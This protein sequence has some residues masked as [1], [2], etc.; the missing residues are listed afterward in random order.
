MATNNKKDDA[1]L[2]D[3]DGYI[4]DFMEHDIAAG[5]HWLADSK[6]QRQ[7]ATSETLH[8]KRKAQHRAKRPNDSNSSRQ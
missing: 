4:V 7:K 8:G 2:G 3:G 6:E 1:V 5:K